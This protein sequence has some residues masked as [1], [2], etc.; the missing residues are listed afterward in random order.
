MQ[1][2]RP[3]FT[4][5]EIKTALA[6]ILHRNSPKWMKMSRA[7]L[8]NREDAEDVLSEAVYRML[9]RG[10]SF[11][12][13]D[14]MQLYVGRIVRNTALEFYSFKKRKKRQY[15]QIL[16][17]IITKSAEEQAEAFRPDFIMEEEERYSENENRL[18]LLRRGLQELPAHQYEAIRL[19][20]FSNSGS[21]FR[22]AET[23]SGIPRATLRYRYMLGMKALRKYMERDE[24]KNQLRVNGDSYD[25]ECGDRPI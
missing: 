16:E 6:A 23:V 18:T 12:S 19:V 14:H 22:D 4:E 7:I 3:L 9:R 24:K 10:L 25:K 2:E 13:Q 15:A 17:S 21:T 8:K 1:T 11:P 20:A 5:E